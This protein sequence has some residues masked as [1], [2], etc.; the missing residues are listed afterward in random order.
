MTRYITARTARAA[1]AAVMF[2]GAAVAT[3]IVALTSASPPAA[4][5]TSGAPSGT[6]PAPTPSSDGNPWG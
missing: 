2:C 4:A 3:P 5:A 1:I 6:D